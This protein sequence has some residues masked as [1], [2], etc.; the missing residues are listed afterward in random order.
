MVAGLGSSMS[1][2][3]LTSKMWSKVSIPM[4][5]KAPKHPTEEM[6]QQAPKQAPKHPTEE[7][8]Q[9]APK[10]PT[11]EEAQQAPKQA[12]KHPTEEEEEA[13]RGLRRGLR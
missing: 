5:Q 4:A 11:A 13:L 12:P 9:Q 2:P 3:P 7:M 10:H 6:A 1:S 8:A